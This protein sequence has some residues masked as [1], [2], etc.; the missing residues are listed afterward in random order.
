MMW[1]DV[2]TLMVDTIK[3]LAPEKS[4][5]FWTSGVGISAWELKTKELVKKTKLKNLMTQVFFYNLDLTPH[6]ELHHWF[7][8]LR[9]SPK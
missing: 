9:P 8:T 5:A 7:S 2:N 3:V 1:G 4:L 6:H